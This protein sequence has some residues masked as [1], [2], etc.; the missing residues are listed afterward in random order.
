MLALDDIYIMQDSK[1]KKLWINFEIDKGKLNQI[2]VIQRD[3]CNYFGPTTF[4]SVT[5]TQKDSILL[6]Q[7]TNLISYSK[8]PTDNLPS[9]INL[10]KSKLW[11][12]YLNTA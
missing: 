12:V 10:Y 5:N 11:Y 2:E 4:E 8:F 7:G 3:I 6:F 9:L 1:S